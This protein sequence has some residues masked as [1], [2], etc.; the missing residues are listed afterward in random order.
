MTTSGSA[1]PAPTPTTGNRAPIASAGSDQTIP[2]SWNYSPLLNAT[3]SKDPDG[4]L[5]SIKW[6]KISGPAS[7]SFQN[8]YAAQTKVYKLAAG[9]YIFRVTV[10]D[11]KGATAYDDVRITI[12][13]S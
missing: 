6:T 2:R 1:T 3:L 4:W 7:F 13:N 10:T 5:K 8:Y 9:S 12:T 11:N